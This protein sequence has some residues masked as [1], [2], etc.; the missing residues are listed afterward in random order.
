MTLECSIVVPVYNSSESLRELC[1]RIETTMGDL[2]PGGFEL[3]FVDDGS[4]DPASWRTLLELVNQYEFVR[5]VQLMRN[6]G[7]G[8]AVL[9]GLSHARGERVVVMDDDLQHRPEDVPKLLSIE[10]RDIVFAN[11]PN[12]R[13]SMIVKLSSAVKGW[14][15]RILIGVPKGIRVSSY[16]CLRRQV[17][18]GM[19]KVRTPYPF[20]AALLFYVTTDA[21]SVDVVHEARKHGR[22]AFTFSKR[23]KQ[24]SRLLINNSS[25]LLQL[26]AVLGGAMALV[27]IFFG[28]MVIFRALAHGVSV[29]GWASLMVALLFI[30]GA[31]LFS[32]GVMGEYLIRIVSNSEMRPAFIVR[33]IID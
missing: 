3:I 21:V 26:I 9:A 23:L 7:R 13:H 17:V 28:G 5:A 14:F 15:D 11:F 33:K 2:Y 19:L 27:S 32:L 12:K 1:S 22:A 10:D 29:A 25:F 18:E 20:I 16:M 30:G 24:F 31:I 8:S 6:F 4:P